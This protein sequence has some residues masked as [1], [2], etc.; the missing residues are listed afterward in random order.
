MT[1]SVTVDFSQI[2]YKPSHPP[3]AVLFGG[4]ANNLIHTD[5]LVKNKYDDQA[6]FSQTLIFSK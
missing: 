2:S 5:H 6:S 4:H 3:P 1:H